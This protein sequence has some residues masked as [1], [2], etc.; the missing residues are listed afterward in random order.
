VLSTTSYCDTVAAGGGLAFAGGAIANLME[1]ASTGFCNG[2]PGIVHLTAGVNFQSFTVGS[3]IYFTLQGPMGADA[4]SVHSAALD[5][6]N[7]QV[8]LPN[9]AWPYWIAQSGTR[10]FWVN[11][12]ISGS[13]FSNLSPSEVHCIGCSGSDTVWFTEAEA[14]YGLIADA[15]NVYLLADDGSGNGTTGIYGCSVQTACGANPRVVITGLDGSTSNVYVASDGTYVYVARI[16]QG[17]IVRID[18]MGAMTTLATSASPEAI[19]VDAT[20]N[21]LYYASSSGSVIRVKLD[22][23]AV[24]ATLSRCQQGTMIGLALDATNVYV[25]DSASNYGVFA[26]PR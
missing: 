7:D 24:P 12:A 22:A 9:R 10:T 16:T 6:T 13:S 21:D 11:D 4:G 17:D 3:L 25:L 5:G 14:T 20:T 26:V 1:C 8:L 15:K 18:G 2:P 23:S 19:A